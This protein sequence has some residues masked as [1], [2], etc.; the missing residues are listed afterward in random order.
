MHGTFI[1]ENEITD[2]MSYLFGHKNRNNNKNQ[3]FNVYKHWP[4]A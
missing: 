1:R 2:F 4:S 3:I